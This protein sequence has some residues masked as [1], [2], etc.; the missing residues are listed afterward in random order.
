MAAATA[1]W[2]IVRVVRLPKL[3]AAD[4]P[5]PMGFSRRGQLLD[6]LQVA[7]EAGRHAAVLPGL[8]RWFEETVRGLRDRWP[9]LPPAQAVYP[10]YREPG[11]A[12]QWHP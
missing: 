7:V 9:G 3:L 12:G 4:E 10:A 11:N 1:A 2:A 8:T 5:H 6:T